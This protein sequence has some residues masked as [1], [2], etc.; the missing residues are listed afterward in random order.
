VKNTIAFVL[1][2]AAVAAGALFLIMSLQGEL[3]QAGFNAQVNALRFE[4]ARQSHI[5]IAAPEDR[6]AFD[7]QAL[8]KKHL[9]AFDVIYKKYP[10]QKKPEDAYILEREKK[11]KTGEKDQAT[12]AELRTRFDYLKKLWNG[13]FKQGSYK[14][15]L[16]QQQNGLRLEIMTVDKINDGGKPALQFNVALWGG[17]NNQISFGPMEIQFVREKKETD[18]R[19]REKVKKILAK[20]QSQGGPPN[21]LID[22]PWEWIPEFPAGVMVGYW[23]GIPQ[24]PPDAHKMTMKLDLQLRAIGGTSIPVS[25]EWKNVDV[26]PS[27]KSPTAGEWDQVEAQEASEE[28]LKAA[29]IE[30]EK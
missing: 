27:W 7:R 9:E 8:M 29:G 2:L 12:T 6:V 5:V 18:A 15:V 11:A 23:A 21:I 13:A 10:E 14:P 20:I 19:G 3:D 16:A 26:D 17:I 28:E 4:F 22:K 1:A 25:L 30:V 24:L